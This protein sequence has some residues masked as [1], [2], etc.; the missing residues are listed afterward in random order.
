M[1]Y[2]PSTDE[3]LLISR[4]LSALVLRASKEKQHI[5]NTLIYEVTFSLLGLIT[6]I[7]NVNLAPTTCFKDKILLVNV[8][9]FIK[10]C[11]LLNSFES[12]QRLLTHLHTV[13]TTFRSAW[14][15]VRNLQKLLESFWKSRLRQDENLTHLTL[16]KF[17]A[18]AL[19]KS[20]MPEH[21][22]KTSTHA[23]S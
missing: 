16:K 12:A 20:C 18:I 7:W 1:L 6:K 10:N 13:S 5:L 14:K 11:C 21:R 19:N 17:A 3:S 4:T 22:G 2:Q 8:I 15:I 9:L 23:L